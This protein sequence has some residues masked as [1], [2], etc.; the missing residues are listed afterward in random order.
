MLLIADEVATGFGRT[1]TLFASEQCDITTRP[2]VHRQRPHGRLP[3]DGGDRRQSGAVFDAFLGP[4]LSEFTLY[5]G[6]SFSGNALCAA[7]ARRHLQLFS[8][9][10]VLANVRA[11]ADTTRGAPA[12]TSLR[13]TR[14][15]TSAS[16]A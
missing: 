7:V 8:E 15:A 11:R 1:G 13:S 6:H 16:K 10:D 3:A 12:K 2:D 5:H 9:W 4:D 14:F